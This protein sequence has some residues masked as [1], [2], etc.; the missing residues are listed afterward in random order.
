MSLGPTQQKP[1]PLPWIKLSHRTWPEQAV[2]AAIFLLVSLAFEWL[3]GWLI[4][5]ASETGWTGRFFSPS[6]A[7]QATS[8]LPWTLYH[9]LVAFAMW[10]LWRRYSL[11]L[12][13]IELAVFLSQLVL[14]TGWALSFFAFHAPLFAL[15]I[16]LFLCSNTVLVALL[17][18]KKDRFSGQALIP[19]FLWIF[20]VMGVNM[21]ICIL[22]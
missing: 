11:T 12:L 7:S 17:Y 14:G 10:S 2:G 16:L 18:W 21:A 5:V 6:W 4:Q 20:Y 3:L 19:P 1:Y 22:K 9:I 15:A 8:H 13:K